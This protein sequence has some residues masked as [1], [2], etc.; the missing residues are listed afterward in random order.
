[1][2]G[3]GGKSSAASKHLDQRRMENLTPWK[4]KP[5]KIKDWV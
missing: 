3:N 2:S 5:W 4:I 1:M